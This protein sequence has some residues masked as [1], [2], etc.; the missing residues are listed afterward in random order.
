MP[1]EDERALDPELLI[2]LAP[3]AKVIP[4]AAAIELPELTMIL[5]A[6]P[7]VNVPVPVKTGEAAIVRL[8]PAPVRVTPML[9]EPVMVFAIVSDEPSTQFIDAPELTVM[10]LDEGIAPVVPSPTCNVPPN[11]NVSPA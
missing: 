9:P 1:L 2:K 4:P 7:A 10:V 6:T 8:D 5:P 11:I 3:E